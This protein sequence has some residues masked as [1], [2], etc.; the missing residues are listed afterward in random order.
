[1][2]PFLEEVAEDIIAKYGENLQNCAVIFN[3]KRP[4]AYLQ[5]HLANVLQK[6]FW[7]PSFYTIQ[8]FFQLSSSLKT[9]DSLTQ[10]F[11]LY[12]VYNELLLSEGKKPF[13]LAKFYPLASTIL[14]DFAQIDNDLVAVND[15]FKELEDIAQIDAQFDYLTDDQKTFLT[16]FWASYSEGKHKNQQEQFIQM[17][18]RMPL[19]YQKF[20]AK[21]AQSERSTVGNLYRQLASTPNDF[22]K[23]FDKLIFVGFNALSKT[24]KKLF[25]KWQNEGVAVFY[26]DTDVYY[27]DDINQEAGL[28]M[29]QNLNQNKLINALGESKAYIQSETKTINVYKAQGQVAQAK[30][31]HE[32][33]KNDYL[34]HKQADGIGKIGI[35]LADESLLLPVLQTIPT[36]Y[37]DESQKEIKVN[38]NVTMGYALV[39]SS[40]Y[41]LVDLWLSTQA[42]LN[43]KDK[44]SVNFN[45]VDAFLAHPLILISEKEK[46]VFSN[47][48]LKAQS[49][50]VSLA[51][52]QAQGGMFELFFTPI[53][54]ASDAPQKLKN[55]LSQVFEQQQTANVLKQTDA[56]LLAA[57]IKEL[58]KLE[59]ALTEHVDKFLKQDEQVTQ[60]ISKS[61]V[62]SLIQKVLKSIAVPLA[63]EPLNGIQV[64]GLL[65]SRNLDFEQLYVLGINEGI[66]PQANAANTFI[67]DGIRRAYGLPVL[68][69]QNAISAYMFYRLLQRSKNITLVYNAQQDNNTTGEPSR[70]L[71]QLEYE[72]GCNFKYFQQQQELSVKA[73]EVSMV[74]KTTEVMER[75]DKY[76]N[77]EI[78]LSPSAF[79]SYLN[80]P[81]QFYYRYIAKIEEPKTIQKKVEA[82]S[83]GTMLHYVMQKIYEDLKSK[84]PIITAERIKAAHKNIPSL[85]KK[86]YNHTIFEDENK[87]DELKGRQLLVFE[88]LKKYV[89]IYLNYDEKIAPF[90]IIGLEENL[91][92]SFEF[93]VNGVKKNIRLKGTIDRID[94]INGITRIVDYKTGSDSLKYAPIADMFNPELGKLNKAFVQTMLY[95]HIYE[96]VKG[97][98][99]VEPNLYIIKMIEK[100]GTKFVESI[101]RK[102]TVLESEFL[103]SQKE[104][105]SIFVQQSLAE[106]FNK[107]IP[108]QSTEINQN[109][110]YSP[111]LVLSGH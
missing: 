62:L 108:F 67:P 55:V 6:P 80:C 81:L 19:L 28:F 20:H 50:E 102:S 13:D 16:N 18:R 56:E 42:Q 41:G 5:K 65:E 94:K 71:H 97:K 83:L 15:L 82:N 33:L 100:E 89:E 22:Y 4:A 95:T 30:I 25:E 107:D 31:I 57:A 21:L 54:Q 86:A 93:E 7:S 70:F 66:L 109:L 12:S 101:N 23:K 105:F 78:S 2:K 68:E 39:A 91:E 96:Q 1:M 17:W 37:E 61:F 46:D 58:N 52:L 69:N 87:T 74:E 32:E 14:S 49:V 24:E 85:C 77:G 76:L 48:M 11:T 45:E 64:M 111:Y 103:A 26:F 10:F 51:K 104:E 34:N 88:I 44:Q 43:T 73:K 75:L 59:D 90:E 3:N 9:A 60:K 29:R 98:K 35:V 8:T 36:H 47:S 27:M 106:L 72:S 63:G 92:T 38:L 79:T 53:C 40:V 99:E 110:N 84:N